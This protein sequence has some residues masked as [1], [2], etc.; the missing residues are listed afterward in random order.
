MEGA[1]I[2]FHMH[3]TL[4]CGFSFT[5]ATSCVPSHGLHTVIQPFSPPSL[6]SLPFP[7][8]SSL[9]PLPPSFIP[10]WLPGTH[11][12]FDKAALTRVK[13]ATG[14]RDILYLWR[15]GRREA[16]TEGERGEGGRSFNTLTQTFLYAL[17]SQPGRRHIRMMRGCQGD[18]ST[19]AQVCPVTQ[20]T[21]T[22]TS[23]DCAAVNSATGV[24]MNVHTLPGPLWG[25]QW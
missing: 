14:W 2:S 8:P 25:P 10:F 4:L 19:Q 17:P 18:E 13:R 7:F 5:D 3:W 9:F 20:H 6:F 21:H 1:S 12:S 16:G 23:R 11:L 22:C 15:Q 24:A